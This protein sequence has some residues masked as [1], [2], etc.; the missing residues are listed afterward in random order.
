M[1]VELT[2]QQCK[3]V[4]RDDEAEH[5]ATKVSSIQNLL[6]KQREGALHSRLWSSIYSKQRMQKQ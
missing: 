1:S 3:T 5:V 6:D 4:Q 2:E